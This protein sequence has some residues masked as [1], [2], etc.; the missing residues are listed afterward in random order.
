M[1]YKKLSEIEAKPIPR[2][3]T[4]FD[5]LDFVYGYSVFPEATYWGLPMGKISLWAGTCGIG[6]SRLAID[7]AKKFSQDGRV[8]YFQTEASL[9][10][11]A[12]WAKNSSQYKN[13]YCSG[14]NKIDE[15]IKIIYELKP[16]LVI[17]D[18]V[19]EIEEF[20][21]GN[22]KETRRLIYGEDGS[23]GL[24]RA[25]AENQS[26]LILLGQLNSD[27]S[28]KGGTSLPHL[29]DIAL[30]LTL[31]EDDK[32]LFMV[33][34]GVKHRYGRR[35]KNICAIFEHKEYGVKCIDQLSQSDSKWCESHGL[36]TRTRGEW[37]ADVPAGYVPESRK[38]NFSSPLKK[39]KL[40]WDYWF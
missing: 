20:C 22:K 38:N 11:F 14:E 7:V 9:E 26:H 16:G 40:C 1:N 10:D 4:G 5:E 6:K 35:D 15:M 25:I 29:V 28:I 31:F 39:S 8:L 3:L 2:A 36:E 30:N 32:S 34:V 23:I 21:N 12:G 27:G 37:L 13:F 17:I 24:N 18:S 19:N 33:S